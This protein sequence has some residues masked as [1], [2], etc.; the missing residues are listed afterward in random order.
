[1][2]IS[3]ISNGEDAKVLST[4]WGVKTF[5]DEKFKHF[6]FE[7]HVVEYKIFSV[8]EPKC[9]FIVLVKGKICQCIEMFRFNR[10]KCE[11]FKGM[12]TF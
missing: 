4:Y 7:Q 11:K 2:Q 12:N 10:T 9:E 5:M 1:M 8:L 6:C 3:S